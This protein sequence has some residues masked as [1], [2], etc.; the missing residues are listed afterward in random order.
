MPRF[1]LPLLLAGAA[2]SQGVPAFAA[3]PGPRQTRA[4][5]ISRIRESKARERE[6]LAEDAKQRMAA[7]K[8]WVAAARAAKVRGEAPPAANVWRPFAIP[9]DGAHLQGWTFTRAATPR[10]SRPTRRSTCG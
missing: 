5:Y 4:E 1:A 9:E 8:R 6:L 7:A 10:T 3:G 2:L